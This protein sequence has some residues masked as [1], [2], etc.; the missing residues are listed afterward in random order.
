[1][2]A[3]MLHVCAWCEREFGSVPAA[4]GQKKTHGICRRHSVEMLR[5]AGLS[6]E[7]VERKLA[8]RPAGESCSDLS[9]S[10]NLQ[11]AEA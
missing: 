1:M 7:A 8:M 10:H 4:P 6:A 2:N 9:L 11:L 5:A 3:E